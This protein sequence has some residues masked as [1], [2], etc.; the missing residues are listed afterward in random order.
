MREFPSSLLKNVLSQNDEEEGETNVYGDPLKP[1]SDSSMATTG[2]TR[3]G[4]C[5]LH[6]KDR[7]SHHICVKDIAGRKSGQ[8]FCTITGQPDWCSETQDGKP[9]KNWCVCEW[10]YE[11]F[12]QADEKNCDL[13]E[14]DC[15]ATNHLAIDHYVKTG[16]TE[17]LKCLEKKCFGRK[18]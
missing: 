10:A 9:R 7:G 6:L 15:D 4:K 2:Y 18:H 11:R 16:K 5:S 14:I 8:N 12:L 17:A 1:C 13:L 3:D